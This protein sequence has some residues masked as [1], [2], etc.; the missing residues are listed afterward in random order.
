MIQRI[1]SIY[2]LLITILYGLLFYFPVNE[3]MTD[4]HILVLDIFGLYEQTSKGLELIAEIYPTLILAVLSVVLSFVSIF[5]FKNRKWQMKLTAYGAIISLGM[6]GIFAYYLYE[7]STAND[8]QIGFSVG[9]ILPVVAFVLQVLT[10]K[11]ILKDE[12]LV[13]S[14]DRIR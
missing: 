7:I 13:R 5:L 1:Q 4:Q 6:I 3:M 14:I 8:T 9:L 12:L 10:Y 2:L 11:A